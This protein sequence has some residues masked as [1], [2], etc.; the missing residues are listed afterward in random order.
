MD[1]GLEALIPKARID[2]GTSRALSVNVWRQIVS[3][4][5]KFPYITGKKIYE[6]LIE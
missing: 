3:Y 1:G 5:E 4:R 6:K 2:L